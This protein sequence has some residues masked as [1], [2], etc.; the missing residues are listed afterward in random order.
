LHFC[1][2]PF[3]ERA[4]V[5]L[6]MS[7][8]ICR[9][10]FYNSQILRAMKRMGRGSVMT[11][12]IRFNPVTREVEIEGTEAFVEKY[13]RQIQELFASPERAAE[14][15]PARAAHPARKEPEEPARRPVRRPLKKGDIFSTVVDKIRESREGMMTDALMRETGFSQ[16]QVRSVIFRAEKQGVIYRSRRGVYCAGKEDPPSG[17]AAEHSDPGAGERQDDTPDAGK[18]I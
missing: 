2:P 3:Y 5:V 10:F 8:D 16:Q 13:F 12:K 15:P 14:A 11:S 17:T 7:I 18:E 9:C 1:R 6:H 4:L